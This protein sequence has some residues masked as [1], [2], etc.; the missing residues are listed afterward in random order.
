LSPPDVGTIDWPEI[1]VHWSRDAGRIIEPSANELVRLHRYAG[2]VFQGLNLW[3]DRSVLENIT[4]GPRLILREDPDAIEK[5]TRNLCERLEIGQLVTL[6]AWQLS[7]GERQRVALARALMMQP[8]ALLLDE[9][10]SALD[11]ILTVAV[12][13]YLAELRQQGLTMLIISHHL[14]FAARVSDRMLYLEKGRVI[15]E[16]PPSELFDSP[17]DNSVK[18]FLSMVRRAR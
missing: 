16:G 14:D 9:I 8:R 1:E 6:W 3:D 13:E 5:R 4:L 10:T 12:M 18:Q 11:A 15:Q 17:A 7:G 2:V